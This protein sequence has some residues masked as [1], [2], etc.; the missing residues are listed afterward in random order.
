MPNLLNF[1]SIC[2]IL[3]SSICMV[4]IKATW[5]LVIPGKSHWLALNTYVPTIYMNV[6]WHYKFLCYDNN[7]EQIIGYSWPYG[8]D[9]MIHLLTA[10][11]KFFWCN[12]SSV[13]WY[14][15]SNISHHANDLCQH[16]TK[17][18]VL[19]II[20]HHHCSKL[21]RISSI[22]ISRSQYKPL[23]KAILRVLKYLKHVKHILGW[24]SN[25]QSPV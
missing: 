23:T 21:N 18:F 13:W 17:V 3:W 9:I 19:W 16:F 22:F 10:R 1:N 6:Y 20:I 11:P 24:D 25:H 7:T 5:I 14:S 12:C 15:E 8:R 2:I 4:S